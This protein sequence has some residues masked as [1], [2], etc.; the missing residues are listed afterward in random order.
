MSGR[1]GRDKFIDIFHPGSDGGGIL[2]RAVRR[3]IKLQRP[4]AESKVSETNSARACVLR[5]DNTGPLID[6]RARVYFRRSD[7][8]GDSVPELGSVIQIGRHTNGRLCRR[9]KRRLAAVYSRLYHYKC[10]SCL[11]R[12]WSVAAFATAKSCRTI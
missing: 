1:R 8:D 11:A 3:V 9:A 5:A 6:E 4:R 2:V 12:S 10:E 7:G